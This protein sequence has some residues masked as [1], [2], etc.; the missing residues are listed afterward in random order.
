MVQVDIG[1]LIKVDGQQVGIGQTGTG[2]VGGEA[3]NVQGRIDGLPQG[4]GGKIGGARVPFSLAKID[5]N[6]DPLVTVVFDGFDLATAN[7]DLLPETG[8][9][10]DLAGA[11]PLPFGVGE[12]IPRQFLQRVETVAEA[13]F[14]R[15]S[16]RWTGHEDGGQEQ[17]PLS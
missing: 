15:G 11:R 14:G 7:R 1:L 17:K 12:N 2:I 10:V 3:G 16:G 5:R 13:R 8:R 9:D 4:G 6:G